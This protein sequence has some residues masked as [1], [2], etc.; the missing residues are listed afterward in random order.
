ME[1]LCS[2]FRQKC[3]ILDAKEFSP[4]RRRR[5]WWTNLLWGGYRSRICN[6]QD[7]LKDDSLAVFKEISTLT[8]SDNSLRQKIK[9]NKT[10]PRV[11]N[12]TEFFFE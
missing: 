4:Q 3:H 8:R 5:A 12:I 11:M 7:Y 2:L 6:L 1:L 10:L 9:G